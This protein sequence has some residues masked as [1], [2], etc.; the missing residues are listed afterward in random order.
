MASARFLEAPEQLLKSIVLEQIQPRLGLGGDVVQAL[1][2]RPAPSQV[3]Q[4]LE[5][6]RLRA[7]AA[8]ERAEI[9]AQTERALNDEHVR[10]LRERLSA[11]NSAGPASMERLF[12][13]QALPSIASSMAESMRDMRFSVF[14]TTGEDGKG[15]TPFHFALQQV[16]ELLHSRVGKAGTHGLD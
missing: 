14:Q 3:A 7:E 1:L 6:E 13:E 9:E 2:L 12:V 11:E 8:R 16:V 10:A 4:E 15:I 5:R